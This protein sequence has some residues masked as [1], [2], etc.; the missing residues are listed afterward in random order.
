MVEVDL[1][2]DD[3]DSEDRPCM[4]C[5]EPVPVPLELCKLDNIDV[6]CND[7]FT[8]GPPER[9]TDPLNSKGV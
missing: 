8:F 6:V 3:F 5:N 1:A 7:C 9:W 2:I 4:C